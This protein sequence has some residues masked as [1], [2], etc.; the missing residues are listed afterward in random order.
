MTNT[1]FRI[2]VEAGKDGTRTKECPGGFN[3]TYDTLFLKLG[4]RCVV[5]IILFYILLYAWSILKFF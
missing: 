1:K 3:N 5:F 4:R 2:M